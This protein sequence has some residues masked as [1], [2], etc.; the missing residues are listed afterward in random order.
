MELPNRKK[1]RLDGFDYSSEN[2]YFVTI[3]TYN[4]AKLF[5][6]PE[7]LNDLG[8]IAEN[9]LLDIVNHHKGVKIDKYVI[10]PNH[11]HE[12]I[13]IGCDPAS[14]TSKFSS[15]ETV[16]GLY[17]SG[18]SRKIHGVAPK[19]NVWQKSYYEHIIRNDHDYGEIWKYIEYNPIKWQ[20]DELYI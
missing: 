9:D 12:I 8:K 5:G 18:V 13:V 14:G 6:E 10:M 4:K 17:K 19:L 20:E 11:I 1:L 3:C 7:R 2:F 16:I 15:L